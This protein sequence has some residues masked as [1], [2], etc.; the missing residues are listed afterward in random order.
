KLTVL[1][2]NDAETGLASEHGLSVAVQ[3]GGET[4]IFDTGQSSAL[5]ATARVLGIDV[6]RTKAVVISHN[7]YDHAGGLD[8]VYSLCLPPLYVAKGIEG[9]FFEGFP[10]EAVN[11][12]DGP[13]EVIPGVIASGPIPRKTIFESP[14]AD[15]PEDQALIVKAERASALLVG[16]A[17]AG[18]INTLEFAA[19]LTGSRSFDI[20]L[21]GFHLWMS[22]AELIGKTAGA[23]D[24][25]DIRTLA[26]GH[27][28]GG[29]ALKRFDRELTAE[30]IGCPAGTTFEL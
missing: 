27:C 7:H 9:G 24:S 1:I 2:E 14:R 8:A 3:S 26:L 11:V 16:C 20:V 29:E 4:V 17:H 10:P 13:T 30:V 28:T 23:L 22:G 19:K 12:I 15:V 25:F 21:G 5:A 18:A 6:A